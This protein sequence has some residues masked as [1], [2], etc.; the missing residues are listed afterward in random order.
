M[1]RSQGGE[2]ERSSFQFTGSA[3]SRAHLI[4]P[5][6]RGF[7]AFSLGDPMIRI[8]EPD[9]ELVRDGLVLPVSR[10]R[11]RM[12]LVEVARE[13]VCMTWAV[14]F[15]I[16]CGV[17]LALVTMPLCVALLAVALFTGRRSK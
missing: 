15:G 13:A 17:V 12:G 14:L 4:M 8:Y 11:R 6:S 16:L 9:F 7:G 10:P 2:Y 1:C 5:L 3:P